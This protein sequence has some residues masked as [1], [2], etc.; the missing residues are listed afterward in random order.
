MLSLPTVWA[1]TAEPPRPELS[2]SIN[3]ARAATI[4]SGWPLLLEL[5]IAHSSLFDSNAVPIYLKADAGNWTSLIGIKIQNGG[6]VSVTWPLRLLNSPANTLTLDSDRMGE[7]QWTLSPAQTAALPAGIYNV[8]VILDTSA[9][10]NAITWKGA[11]SFGPMKVEISPEPVP[12]PLAKLEQKQRTFVEYYLSLGDTVEA[13]NQVNFLLNTD[14]NNVSG[15]TF[16]ASILGQLNRNRE[17]LLAAN[18]ALAQIHLRNPHP[19]EPPAILLQQRAE[20][21][22]LLR[23]GR[24][25]SA[26]ITNGVL[27]LEWNASPGDTYNLESS[28]NLANWVIRALGLF[29]ETNRFVWSTNRLLDQ[30][31]FRVT[32]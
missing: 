23:P 14:S 3:D 19:A 12:L 15:L 22:Q 13:L 17:A 27:S 9:Q 2:A 25:N 5:S 10:V 4:Y 8:S 1:R 6:G 24:I 32:P 31:F 26:G 21:T 20:L 30:E 16:K 18:Q 29:A 11:I 28:T 7:L